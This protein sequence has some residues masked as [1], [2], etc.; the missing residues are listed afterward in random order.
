MSHSRHRSRQTYAYLPRFK[1]HEPVCH[2][3]ITIIMADHYYCLSLSLKL[4]KNAEIK[5]VLKCRILVGGP[6][7]EKKEW[8]VFQATNQQCKALALSL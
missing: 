6:F 8:P 3:V 7:V 4:W 2:R 5:N 1:V